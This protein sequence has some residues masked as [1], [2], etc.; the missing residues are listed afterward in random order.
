MPLPRFWYLPRGNKAVIIMTGDDHGN[1]GTPGRFDLYKAASAPGCS[2]ENWGCI[3]SSSYIYP[4][5]SIS[6]AVAAAYNADG[7]EIGVH[8]T[9]NCADWTPANLPPFYT[10][11]LATF[12][13]NFPDLP[14]PT[15]NRT[16]CI[17]WSDYTTQATVELSKGIRLDTNYYYYPQAWVLDRPGLFT[18]SGMPMRFADSTGVLIDVYQAT[19][20]MTDESGQTYGATAN[21]LL[22]KA[23]GPEGYYGAFTANMHTDFNSTTD[24]KHSMESSNAIVA[25][26]QARGVPIVS[27]RQMLQ[28][29]DGRNGSSFQDLTWSG[30]VLTFTVGVYSGA[31][32]LQAMVPTTVT[33][34]RLTTLTLNGSAAPFTLQTVKGVEYAIFTVGAGTYRATYA[35]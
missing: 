23:I 24:P 13:S 22:D 4:N 10:S 19:T 34:G 5:T 33:A 16:H 9:T 8:V 35:P 1:A 29:L 6:D 11:Q 27:S 28:W 32:G 18:G 3:R 25:S 17:A 14:A 2:V 12:A 26:A 21:A 31:N 15:T 7:F 30:S 20:Q